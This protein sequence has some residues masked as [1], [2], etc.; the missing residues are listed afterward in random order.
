VH[1]EGKAPGRTW[2]LRPSS[3]PGNESRPDS[4]PAVK[5]QL[6]DFIAWVFGRA[7]LDAAA[8]LAQPLNRRLPAC[9]RALKVRTT[10]DAC[11]LVEREPT[12]VTTAVS[13]LLIGVTEFFREPDVFEGIRRE[14]LPSLAGLSRP[15]RIWS[16]ACSNGAELITVA[17]LLSEAGLLDRGHLLGTDCRPDAIDEAR[18]GRYAAGSLRFMD[19]TL[20]RRYLEPIGDFWRPK[21]SL[22]NRIHWKVADTLLSAEDGPWH[23]ILWRNVGIYLTTTASEAVWSRLLSVLSPGGWLITGKAERPQVRYR[24][25]CF[26]RC[27]YRS[28]GCPISVFGRVT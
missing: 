6:D 15:L 10:S 22:R 28:D 27:I 20:R 13:A 21:A 25:K 19:P 2:L 5:S 26:G 14:V 17:I 23:V 24:M 9:L 18:R 1:F 8:Y 12:A 3:V 11:R 16:A 7:G 4:P